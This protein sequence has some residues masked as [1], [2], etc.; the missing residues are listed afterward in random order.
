MYNKIRKWPMIFKVFGIIA[1]VIILT[2]GSIMGYSY[3]TLNKINYD[4]GSNAVVQE[5]KFDTLGTDDKTLVQ[6]DESKI[7]FNNGNGRFVKNIHNILLLAEDQGEAQWRGNTDTIMILTI[8]E[9]DNTIK[10]TSLM[11]DI[12]VVIPGYSQNKLNSAYATGGIQLLYDTIATNFDVS[13]EG[14]I[15]VNYDTCEKIIDELGGV[16]VTLSQEEADYLNSTNYVSNEK[17]RNISAGTQT[18]N[19]NQAVG[20]ARIRHIGKYDF[21]RTQRQRNIL[22]DIYDKFKNKDITKLVTMANNIFPLITTDLDTN[23]IIDLGTKIFSKDLG[24][25]EQ[26]RIPLDN[27]YE[28]GKVK[29]M[30]SLIID[31]DTNV[32]TLH[33]FIF[34]SPPSEEEKAVYKGTGND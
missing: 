7:D 23:K 22:L 2:F 11:R 13:C 8:N 19:G 30:S 33:E 34:G 3:Y 1:V 20:Y 5:E 17:N 14:Y 29:N 10:L 9:N 24:E 28:S 32:D 25:L 18:L 26:L 15:L 21:E 12:Y 6:V 16:T 27:T 31:F 4:D